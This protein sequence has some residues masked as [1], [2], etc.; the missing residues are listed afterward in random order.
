MGPEYSKETNDDDASTDFTHV[1]AKC[2]AGKS[3]IYTG[4]KPEN[5]VDD[6]ID[7]GNTD[8]DD[9][10]FFREDILLFLAWHIITLSH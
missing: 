3:Q 7:N 9:N 2:G 1:R 5:R 10:N 6:P 8:G 4:K